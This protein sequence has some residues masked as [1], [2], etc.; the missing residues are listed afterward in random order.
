MA[1]AVSVGEQMIGRRASQRTACSLVVEIRD[2]GSDWNRAQLK[3]ISDSG[4]RLTRTGS[5]AKGGSLW[6]RLPG[7][8]P[9][10]ARVRWTSA[11][12]LGCQFL[13]PLDRNARAVLDSLLGN[14]GSHVIASDPPAGWAAREPTPVS[15]PAPC[16][17]AMEIACLS[18]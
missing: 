3:D 11:D 9:I 4:C 17:P 12:A 14:V 2:V 1:A 15:A 8:E 5:F 10:A 6:L 7:I 18:Q 13:Y 16:H